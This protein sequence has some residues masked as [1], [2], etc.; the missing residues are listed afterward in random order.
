MNLLYYSTTQVAQ[1]FGVTRGTIAAWVKRG[2]LPK[3][4]KLVTNGRCFF[5]KLA[6]DE[7]VR[8]ASERR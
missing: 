5:P 8:N 2:D 4:V 6:I 7:L 1:M 3:P